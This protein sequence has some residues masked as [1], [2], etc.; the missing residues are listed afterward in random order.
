MYWSLV[1]NVQQW[2]TGVVDQFCLLQRKTFSLLAR[3]RLRRKKIFRSDRLQS[4]KVHSLTSSCLLPREGDERDSTYGTSQ[5]SFSLIHYCRIYSF[6]ASQKYLFEL[7]KV[8]AA[9]VKLEEKLFCSFSKVSKFRLKVF[10]YCGY[11]G[12]QV[13]A[14]CQQETEIYAPKFSLELIIRFVGRKTKLYFLNGKPKT[15]LEK[16]LESGRKI[17]VRYSYLDRQVDSWVGK[18]I[19]K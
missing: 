8:C 13:V 17:Y 2:T 12:R 15:S 11:L 1:S 9:V 19:S 4:A 16:V 14:S 7:R 6:R 18:Q 10:R 5:A 3:A